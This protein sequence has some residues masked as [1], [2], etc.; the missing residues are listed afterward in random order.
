MKKIIILILFTLM[1]LQ[2]NLSE[3]LDV[4]WGPYQEEI[5]PLELEPEVW[6]EMTH[7]TY[8]HIVF[9]GDATQLDTT[10][11][12]DLIIDTDGFQDLYIWIDGVKY[13][14]KPIVRDFLFWKYL[15]WKVE[16]VANED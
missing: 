6:F 11:S 4:N 14:M 15:V 5:V 12:T 8:D 3:S 13:R 2:A 10:F 16:E 9:E 1:M 7:E